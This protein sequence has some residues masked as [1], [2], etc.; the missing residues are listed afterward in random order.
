MG[1]AT[2]LRD[3]FFSVFSRSISKVYPKMGGGGVVRV[4]PATPIQTVEIKTALLQSSSSWFLC[5]GSEIDYTEVTR[6][7][8]LI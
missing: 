5:I 2:I 7:Y 4:P 6:V 1:V 8:S 3:G